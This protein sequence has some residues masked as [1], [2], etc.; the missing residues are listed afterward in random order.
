MLMVKKYMARAH[1]PFFAKNE[2]R[3]NAVALRGVLEETRLKAGK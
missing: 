1:I 2:A 3:H